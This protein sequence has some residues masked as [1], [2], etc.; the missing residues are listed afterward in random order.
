VT[1]EGVTSRG[2]DRQPAVVRLARDVGVNVIAN[3]IAAAI[4]YLLAVLFQLLPRDR[5]AILFALFILIM[6]INVALGTISRA[7]RFGYPIREVAWMTFLFSGAV[8]IGLAGFIT[9]EGRTVQILFWCLSIALL[10]LWSQWSWDFVKARRSP[11]CGGSSVSDVI[12]VCLIR[13]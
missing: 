6:A 2:S 8:G 3:L 7:K 9:P 1:D 11:R 13:S 4:L 10:G 12:R 5:G